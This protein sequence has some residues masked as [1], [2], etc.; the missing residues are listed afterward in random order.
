MICGAKKWIPSK[1]IC[2]LQRNSCENL[3]HGFVFS[4]LP[5]HKLSKKVSNKFFCKL[6]MVKIFR[7][8]KVVLYMYNDR[9]KINA[10][11]STEIVV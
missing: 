9:N 2:F 4:Y 5:A 7:L 1:K 10:E 3:W 11:L 8:E 6:C